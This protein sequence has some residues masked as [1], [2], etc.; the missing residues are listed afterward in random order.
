LPIAHRSRVAGTPRARR[1]RRA[2]RPRRVR[3]PNRRSGSRDRCRRARCERSTRARCRGRAAFGIRREPLRLR[4]DRPALDGSAFHERSEEAV[5]FETRA[6]REEREQRQVAA[7]EWRE[8][9]PDRSSSRKTPRRASRAAVTATNGLV[10]E[11]RSKMGAAFEAPKPPAT[12]AASSNAPPRSQATA[13]AAEGAAPRRTTSSAISSSVFTSP[14]TLW[15][16][17]PRTRL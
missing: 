7:R 6:M 3:A 9:P 10:T 17:P 1:A 13:T 12:P 11:A 5:R 4:R 14:R 2:E 8:Q 15:E 16:S